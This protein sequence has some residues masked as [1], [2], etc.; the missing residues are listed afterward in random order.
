MTIT[1]DNIGPKIAVT[2]AN[3][4]TLQGIVSDGSGVALVEVSLD[5]G[6]TYQL[7]VLNNGQWSFDRTTWA[8]AQVNFAIV[9]TT[10]V[11]D[12]VTQEV[13]TVESVTNYR[14]YLPMISR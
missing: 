7:A 12:N 13:V 11:W 3:T 1:G 5:G 10:D 14:V 2:L 8:G 6:A 9:R 4:T